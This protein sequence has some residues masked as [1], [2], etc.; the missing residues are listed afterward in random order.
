[1]EVTPSTARGQDC[2][3]IDPQAD[4]YLRTLHKACEKAGGLSPLARLLGVR[5]ANLM[6]WL[7]GEAPV[8]QA[9]FLKAVDVLVG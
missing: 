2:P 5:T 7:D 6:R 1:M 8:P 4:F 9:I 3:A